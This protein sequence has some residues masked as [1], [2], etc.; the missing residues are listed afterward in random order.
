ML[1]DR[2]GFKFH[3]EPD[4]SSLD[5]SAFFDRLF[6]IYKDD[7]VE[8][9][10]QMEK[11]VSM[12]LEE[13]N[14][15][16]TYQILP[17]R[18]RIEILESIRND[19]RFIGEPSAFEAEIE[20]LRIIEEHQ[21]RNN[22]YNKT[23]ELVLKSK[24]DPISF[25][26]DW[27][28]KTKQLII[29]SSSAINSEKDLW[30]ER[31][32]FLIEFENWVKHSY[33]ELEG[34]KH[35]QDTQSQSAPQNELILEPLEIEDI[36]QLAKGLPAKLVLLH[37]LGIYDVLKKRLD[38]TV[39]NRENMARLIGYVIGSDKVKYISD[40]LTDP[41]MSPSYTL[42]SDP[43]KDNPY[44]GPAIKEMKR[45]LRECNL[46]PKGEYIEKKKS[47]LTYSKKN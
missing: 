41:N 39:Y 1:T 15:N 23:F 46:E 29:Q 40:F 18:W 47:K 26:H 38:E 2:F 17:I 45:I 20:N 27:Q 14:K 16:E 21:I 3:K 35:N 25:I 11:W 34:D 7:I 12:T 32:S 8:F 37:E 19:Q 5:V 30:K 9:P 43:L 10:P 36:K 44:T 6:G 4:G 24:K 22:I 28:L 42:Y 31:M 13:I 33:F